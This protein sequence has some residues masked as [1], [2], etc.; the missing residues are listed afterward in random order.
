MFRLL[1]YFSIASLVSMVLAAIVL[2]MLHQSF[3]KNRLLRYGE[4]QNITLA[5]AFSSQRLAKIP[6]FRQ[7]GETA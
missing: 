5:Q 2:G 3:E 6:Q 7:C 4:K 1:R